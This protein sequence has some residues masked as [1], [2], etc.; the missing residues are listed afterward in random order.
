MVKVKNIK[1]AEIPF[2]SDDKNFQKCLSYVKTMVTDYKKYIPKNSKQ[3]LSFELE[4]VTSDLANCIRRYLIDE[5]PVYSMNV[6]EENIESDD[7]FILSDFLK[8]NIELIPFSQHISSKESSELTMTLHVENKTDDVISVYSS[9]IEVIDKNK[10]KLNNEKYFTTTIPIIKLR[11]GTMLNIKKINIVSGIG[12]NDSGK[13][14]LLSNISYEILDVV[15]LEENKFSTSGHSSLV[16]NPANFKFTLTTHR[17]ADIKKIMPE[18][19]IAIINSMESIKSELTKI[20]DTDKI[21]FSDLIELE[22]KGDVKLFYFKGEY[23]TIANIISK[24]CYIVFKDIQF[25]CSAII[26]PSTEI[27]I[28]KI[29]HTEPVKILLEALKLIIVD[30]NIINKSF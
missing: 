29:K 22:T 2:E 1:Y 5:I 16:S 4:D 17:N 10:N 9:D 30:F 12:K 28:V 20:K 8:K 6:D 21:Y 13:F 18:C 3:Q 24:Y 19:C 27:S 15:P 26:H 7:R 25:V 11:P 23:W 14:I